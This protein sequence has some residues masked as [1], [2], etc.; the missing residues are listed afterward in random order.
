MAKVILNF[1]VQVE[2]DI[3][4]ASNLQEAAFNID[5]TDVAVLTNIVFPSKLT[6]CSGQIVLVD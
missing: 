6:V 5:K 1:P 2:C 3:E 4:S